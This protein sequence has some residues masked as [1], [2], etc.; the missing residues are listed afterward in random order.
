MRKPYERTLKKAGNKD[1]KFHDL[2]HIFTSHFIMNGGDFMSLRDI[3]GHSNLKMIERYSHLAS[4]YK[5]KMISNLSGKFTICYP[6]CHL[7]TI[8]GNLHDLR[9][10]AK[11]CNLLLLQDSAVWRASRIKLINNVNG[12]RKKLKVK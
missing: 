9:K 6:T 2:Q 5:R 3:L 10:K 8:R 4:D 1:F 12:T 7:T 11:S